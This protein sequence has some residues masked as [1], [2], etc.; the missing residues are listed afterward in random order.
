MK[1]CREKGKKTVLCYVLAYSLAYFLISF[2]SALTGFGY[3]WVLRLV[4]SDWP[5]FFH[6]FLALMVSGSIGMIFGMMLMR[7]FK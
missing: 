6:I 7:I 2:F 1:K 4:G 3:F 5:V